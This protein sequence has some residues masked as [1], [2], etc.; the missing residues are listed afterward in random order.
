MFGETGIEVREYGKSQFAKA[1]GISLTTLRKEL[2]SIED[3][4]KQF[5]FY[6]RRSK[7]LKPIE[8]ELYLIFF[9]HIE[10]S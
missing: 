3:Q 5:P 6:R 2:D 7:R 4:L 1:M 10:E 9:G 8:I